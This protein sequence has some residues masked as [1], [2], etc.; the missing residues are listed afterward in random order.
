LPVFAA[1]QS[2]YIATPYFIADSYLRQALVEKARAGVDVRLLLP[3]HH[4]DNS[5]A[6][7][8]AQARYQELL[9]AGVKIYE[10]KPTFMHAKY[11]VID[12]EWS[13]VG[14]P[15]LNFRSRELDE[16][17][18]LGIYDGSFG[19]RLQRTFLNDL[20][21]SEPIRLDEW[22]RRN[23]MQK[24]FETASRILDQQS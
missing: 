12:G 14:S 22:R 10:Y 21:R 6:R 11:M 3:G 4:T 23:P 1:R 7:A 17:N 13:I 5:I 18:A 20:E 15:N 19:A 2:L 9:E 16:E 24:L 8:S